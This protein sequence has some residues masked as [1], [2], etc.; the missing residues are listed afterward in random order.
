M[1]GGKKKN[2]IFQIQ[3]GSREVTHINSQQLQEHA[4]DLHNLN[5]D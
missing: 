3:Q 2:S 4:Q 5:P 1:V